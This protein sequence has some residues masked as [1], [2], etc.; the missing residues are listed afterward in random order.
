MSRRLTFLIDGF[1]LY[2][3]LVDAQEI[4]GAGVKWLD[5]WAMCRALLINIEPGGQLHET[6]LFTALQSRY[7]NR[8][9]GK[10]AR[11][12]IYLQAIRH[13]GAGRVASAP[14]RP[15][16]PSPAPL[17]PGHVIQFRTTLSG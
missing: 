11:Q 13:T 14:S 10:V 17:P 2:H 9:Q 6:I 1:N 4:D 5:L 7:R 12:S 15:V 3:S 16:P 8:D